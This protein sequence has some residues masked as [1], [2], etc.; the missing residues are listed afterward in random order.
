MCSF[1][2]TFKG[3][4]VYIRAQQLGNLKFVTTVMKD[5]RNIERKSFPSQVR[6]AL[7]PFGFD[8]LAKTKTYYRLRDPGWNFGNR[9]KRSKEN[10]KSLKNKHVGETGFII[11]TGPS[12]KQSNLNLL[13]GET[14]IGLNRL[15]LG[16]ENF[17]L[18]PT[19]MACVNHVLLSQNAHEF[20]RLPMPLFASWQ[21]RKSL[22]GA[23]NTIFIRTVAGNDFYE[24]PFDK[25]PVGSTV[26]YV[27]LQ[28]AHWMG[29]EKVVL[30]GIDHRYELLSH[31]IEAGSHK[32][33]KRDCED[34]NH[35]HSGYVSKG[36]NWQLPDL[37][38]S[39]NAYRVAKAQFE[40]DGRQILDAT[41]GGALDI[42]EK[43]NLQDIVK[44]PSETL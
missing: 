32:V 3:Q 42:F 28:L 20:S 34:R 40:K 31:E 33:V 18:R 1:Y 12:L 2:S 39:E 23:K 16:F 41:V 17:K 26:T 14:S 24:D 21:S 27:A 15:Y 5:V 37:A 9:A 7:G 13:E 29:F 19:Y 38:A 22:N 4:S 6:R 8:A 25:I 35:F 30:V 10:L 11:G 43:V 44:T 36:D